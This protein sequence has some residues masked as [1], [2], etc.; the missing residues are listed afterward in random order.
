MIF[1]LAIVCAA[2]TALSGCKTYRDSAVS[3]GEITSAESSGSVQATE[4]AGWTELGNPLE[5][6]TSASSFA[7]FP[8]DLIVFDGA[9][10]I[11]YGE[12]DNNVGPVAMLRYD[13]SQ[14][15]WING[16]VLPEESI[17]KFY[18]IDGV[19]TC[20]GMDA[21]G[22]WSYG[23]YYTFSESGWISHK[24]I[25]GGVHVF[26]VARCQDGLI[27]GI[28]TN[29]NKDCA[30]F[31]GDD[32]TAKT[33][34]FVY[35]DGNTPDYSSFGTFENYRCFCVFSL[36]G[37]VY[38][39]R[40]RDVYRY[41]GEKFVFFTHW[42]G[43]TYIDPFGAR[44][45]NNTK[46]KAY[47]GNSVYFAFGALYKAYGDAKIEYLPLPYEASVTDV[48]VDRD[49]LYVLAAK[50]EGE[51]YVSTVLEYADGEFIKIAEYT[52]KAPAISLAADGN[53]L[54][55]GLGRK[56]CSDSGLILKYGVE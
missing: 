38:A 50:E 43:L 47:F 18:V 40:N 32:G 54:Y 7:R 1:A 3:A 49:R 37:E 8:Q 46:N 21:T 22:D 24:V 27:F 15:R 36:G 6:R 11:C 25:P 17:E 44:T 29:A 9:L 51:G 30:V 41:D 14:E 39:L 23:N 28:G 19:L 16:G 5:I 12:W 53:D 20:T 45:T 56:N 48:Y 35:S 55:I 33:L 2:V 4:E 13:F 42:T 26:D 10:H 52:G 31:I 34:S